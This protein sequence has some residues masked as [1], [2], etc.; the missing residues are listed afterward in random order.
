MNEYTN[1]PNF[2]LPP[3]PPT[4]RS[5]PPPPIPAARSTGRGSSGPPANQAPSL[6]PRV[7]SA[8]Q[9]LKH[10]QVTPQPAS[11]PNVTRRVS[12]PAQKAAQVAKNLVYVQLP[13]ETK[14]DTSE[15]YVSLPN[16]S[17][18]NQTE[19]VYQALPPRSN[20]TYAAPADPVLKENNEYANMKMLELKIAHA[21][22]EEK[23]LLESPER[24]DTFTISTYKL[25]KLQAKLD[26]LQGLLTVTGDNDKSTKKKY[27][28]GAEKLKKQLITTLKDYDTD[29]NKTLKQI[30]SKNSAILTSEEIAKMH[31]TLLTISD[32]ICELEKIYTHKALEIN[33]K[34]VEI[35]KN[36]TLVNTSILLK[37]INSSTEKNY[38]SAKQELDEFNRKIVEDSPDQNAHQAKLEEALAK[39]NASRILANTV[40]SNLE[41]LS[42]SDR[43]EP[44]VPAR[45]QYELAQAKAKTA[46]LNAVYHTAISEGSTPPVSSEIQMKIVK[47]QEA[48]N[49]SQLEE[50]AVA[51]LE[52][53]LTKLNKETAVSKQRALSDS[54]RTQKFR[55]LYHELANAK[56]KAKTAHLKTI[57]YE[58]LLEGAA[59][60]SNKNQNKIIVAARKAWQAAIQEEAKLT[61][62]Q[63]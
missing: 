39:L 25:A 43:T 19:S 2:E 35:K 59:H 13:A 16:W 24:K 62:Q 54:D 44:L 32:F 56:A 53:A 1:I 5:P 60:V 61:N 46:Y 15:N 27:N 63:K 34:D 41:N 58:A 45:G 14:P 21:K 22:Q 23:A 3:P 37:I 38:E 40:N 28:K 57:Y 17:N 9:G 11:S 18:A 52:D 51:K 36:E 6:Q 4:T 33:L 26:L 42:K 31:P 47:A 55:A 8:S 49:A 7:D 20:S 10:A 29:L 48:L 30:M 50:A 12:G